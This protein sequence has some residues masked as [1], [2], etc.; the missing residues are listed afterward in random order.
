V[1]LGLLLRPDRAHRQ[2]VLAQDRDLLRRVDTVG[3][4]LAVVPA[5]ADADDHAA[6]R[7]RVQARDRLGGHDRL[8]LGGEQD[9]RAER[10]P[11]G[12]ARD[13]GEGDDR[14]G[15][16]RV[17]TPLLVRQLV[18]T[19]HREVGVLADEQRVEPALLQRAPEVGGVDALA[20]EVVPETGLHLFPLIA[21]RSF[22]TRSA[23]A[24][25]APRWVG[26]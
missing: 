21:R 24:R 20:G 22:G 1:E 2:H 14:V 5:R 10:Q 4:Q 17:R 16:P 25:S 8:V 13:H 11:F 3:A 15:H 7:E 23:S 26:W 9:R 18:R 12:R 6:A 19:R